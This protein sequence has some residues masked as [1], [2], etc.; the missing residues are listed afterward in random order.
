MGWYTGDEIYDAALALGFLIA[1]ITMIAA[2]FVRTPYGRF[3]DES[4]GASLDP[5]LGW[6]LMELPA[7]LSF[8]YFYVGGANAREPF[9]LFVLFVW[10]VHYGNR[11]FLMPALMRV[12]RGQKSSFGLMVVVMG[13]GVTSLHGYL[14]GRWAS[15]LS[16]HVGWEWFSDPRFAIGILLYYVG[17][18]INIHS[19][20]VVRNLRTKDEVKRGIKEYRIPRGGLFEYV[21]NPSYF[22]E[23]LFWVGFS[24]FTWSLAGVYILAISMANLIP[25]AVAT[26]A[27]YRE[28]FPEYP[29]SRRILIP[30]VW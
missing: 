16:P 6:F 25:R 26:H 9:A 24:I 13:W 27:W 1:A 28:K 21:S 19:D 14:N 8:V 4:Y 12:P 20:H 29:S 22:S 3:A 5:R 30:L 2:R 15:S 11:G 7:V 10:G 17:L 23:L 18:G